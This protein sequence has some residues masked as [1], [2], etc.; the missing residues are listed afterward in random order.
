V[1]IANDVEVTEI[2]SVL[3]IG[4]PRGKP[5]TFI[6]G[7]FRT[8]QKQSYRAFF[9]SWTRLFGERFGYSLNGFYVSPIRYFLYRLSNV[10]D[11]MLDVLDRETRKP[12]QK[13]SGE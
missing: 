12:D 13:T 4:A 3:P 5:K 8:T 7:T 1:F 9:D 11:E 10:F 6:D 2:Q